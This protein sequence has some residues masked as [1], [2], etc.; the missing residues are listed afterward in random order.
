MTMR[1]WALLLL[2]AAAGA[3][4]A[5]GDRDEILAVIQATFDG[6]AS[7]DAAKVR[8]TLTP[9]ARVLLADEAKVR[10]NV[11]G[12]EFARRVTAGTDG[13]EERMS[14]PK[15]R[16]RGRIAAV[17]ADYRFFAGG[18]LSHCGIDAF[19][20]VRTDTGWRIFSIVSTLEKRGCR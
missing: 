14:H 1:L 17:W 18:T 2:L 11:S 3:P 5:A 10:L 15:V 9:D 12:D 13:I 7:H 8:A 16:V 19:H 20:L 6:M 4:L